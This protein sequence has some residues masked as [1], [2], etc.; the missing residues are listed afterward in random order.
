MDAPHHCSHHFNWG[1]VNWPGL[2]L[3][4]E[5]PATSFLVSTLWLQQGSS[6]SALHVLT[7][8]STGWYHS[9]MCAVMPLCQMLHLFWIMPMSP[10]CYNLH[11]ITPLLCYMFYNQHESALL[12]LVYNGRIGCQLNI[13]YTCWG[14]WN[15]CAANRIVVQCLHLR[16]AQGDVWITSIPNIS[17]NV[18][19]L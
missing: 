3:F 12:F 5:A 11:V 7:C 13:L 2:L 14:G 9:V 18:L 6:S 16:F 10:R 19:L 4:K 17:L 8:G 1:R 15:I